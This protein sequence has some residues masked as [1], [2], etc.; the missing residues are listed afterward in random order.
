[1]MVVVAMRVI[2]AV[3]MPVIAAMVVTMG[4]GVRRLVVR[5]MPPPLVMGMIV[6]AVVVVV[7]VVRAHR[8]R[9]Y[10]E[11]AAAPTLGR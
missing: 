4:R 8:Y 11:P 5:G 10:P 7:V 2:M 9:A 1:M 3:A 6:V